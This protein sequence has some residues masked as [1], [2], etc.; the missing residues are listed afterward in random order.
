MEFTEGEGKREG[1][2]LPN[3]YKPQVDT[4]TEEVVREAVK[5]TQRRRRWSRRRRSVGTAVEEVVREV[6]AW[7][8]RWKRRSGEEDFGWWWWGRAFTVHQCG[9]D[10]R[11][12]G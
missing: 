3:C 5:W 2:G 1:E 11:A 12:D 7:T 4:A 9:D 6:A 8:P 10:G